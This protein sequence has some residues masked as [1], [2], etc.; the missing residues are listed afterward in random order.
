MYAQ[1][2]GLLHYEAMRHWFDS[3][4]N[5]ACHSLLI[6]W[7]NP[8]LS[9]RVACSGGLIREPNGLDEQDRAYLLRGRFVVGGLQSG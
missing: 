3:S 4:R 7:L 6:A 2:R 1:V 8:L 5:H 9:S